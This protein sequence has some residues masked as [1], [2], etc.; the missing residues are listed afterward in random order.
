MDSEKKKELVVEGEGVKSVVEYGRRSAVMLKKIIESRKDKVMIG[1][2]QYLQFQDWQTIAKFYR[3][4]VGVEW[5]KPILAGE[6]VFGYEAKAH[7]LNDKGMVVSSAESSC[8]RDEPTWKARPDF[9][10]RS[11]AQTRSCAKALRNVFGWV[12]VLA[13]FEGTPAEEMVAESKE[14]SDLVCSYCGARIAQK[15]FQFSVDRYGR[16]LCYPHQKQF[17]EF[18]ELRDE[19][20]EGVVAE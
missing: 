6:K 19:Q 1:G 13:G 10:L 11:M 14:V 2:R 16:A 4:T 15:V 20:E 3:S 7:V 5:T 9:Q 8:S 18:G 17:E 12:V